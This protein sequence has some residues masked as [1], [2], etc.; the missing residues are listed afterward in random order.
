MLL[1][2]KE[3]RDVKTKVI[4]VPSH[5]DITHFQ[6]IPQVPFSEGIPLAQ[7]P[8]IIAV[9]NPCELQLNDVRIS[10]IN[11]DVVKDMCPNIYAKNMEPA[12]I[13]LSLRGILEQRIYYP[14]Y[15]SNPETP[16]EYDH[17]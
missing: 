9:S 3:L 14:L 6:P 2:Q 8:P 15:P 11:T 12:K 17:I 10:I 1:I 16:I 4:V 7:N 13:D 5:K